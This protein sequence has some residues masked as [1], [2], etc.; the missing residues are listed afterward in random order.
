MASIYL[1]L[2]H[3]LVH[4]HAQSEGNGSWDIK[5]CSSFSKVVNRVHVQLLSLKTRIILTL[6]LTFVLDGISI[7]KGYLMSFPFTILI[8]EILILMQLTRLSAHMIIKN[9]QFIFVH[10]RIFLYSFVHN[11]ICLTVWLRPY[12]FSIGTK[13]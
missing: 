4:L 8:F 13:N 12:C 1:R 11:I 10:F 9:C 5:A 6:V 2:W 7:W 3:F